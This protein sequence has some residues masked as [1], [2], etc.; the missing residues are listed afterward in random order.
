MKT[1]LALLVAL[2]VA[3][4][5]AW[6]NRV[7][8]LMWALPKINDVMDPIVP[9]APT[10]WQRGPATAARPPGE[11]PPNIILIFADDLGYNDVSFTNGGAADGSVQ[12]PHLDAIAREGV[13]FTNGYAANAICAPSR[14]S[15][16]TGRYS[17]RF[18]F[19]FTPFPKIA[20]TFADWMNDGEAALQPV[21]HH[22]L[23]DELPDMS[24]MA[25]PGD[26]V[27]IAEVLSDAG[28]YTAH[29]GKWHLGGAPG[30]RPED[31]GFDDSLYM[32]GTLYLPGDHPDVVNARNDE[33]PIERMVWASSRYSA[34][35]TADPR[36]SRTAT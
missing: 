14:A 1:A 26:E 15:M 10:A 5:A 35:G 12:T 29:I 16:L 13:L 23:V 25:L 19:E 7:D 34:N 3:L 20:L 21:I 28:Y 17:T 33:S 9:N 30:L 22:D 11:R 24:T 6:L 36:S 18:G 8:L 32:S 27:T 2:A 31:Q 4:A